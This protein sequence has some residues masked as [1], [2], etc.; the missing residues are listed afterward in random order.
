M[1]N[2]PLLLWGP[3]WVP[4]GTVVDETVQS[5]DLMP[6]LIELAGLRVPDEA[7]GQSLLPFL[8]GPGEWRPRP[9]ISERL[10]PDF[11]HEPE[12]DDVESYSIVDGGFRLI[13]NVTRPDEM[14]E[15]ELYDHVN[16]PLNQVDLAAEMSSLVIASRAFQ[17][18]LA[19]YQS[20]EEML[21]NANQLA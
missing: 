1:T 3:R 15:F 7:Q 11:E 5:I 8:G 13:H 19:A 10:R 20:V 4:P 17:L 14:P 21:S 2:V 6:T 12:P 9:A 16:D 18:N